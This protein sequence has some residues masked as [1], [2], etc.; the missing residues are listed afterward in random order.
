MSFVL[1]IVGAV[2]KFF[3]DIGSAVFK[4]AAAIFA[5]RLGKRAAQQDAAE[6]ALE[7]KDEQ[8]KHAARRPRDRSDVID[9]M[10]DDDL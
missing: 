7:V 6:D 2:G 5:Y 10:R 1:S 3:A 4:W 9:R 8:L